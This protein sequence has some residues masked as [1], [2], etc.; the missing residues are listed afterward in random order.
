[1]PTPPSHPRRRIQTYLRSDLLEW[2]GAQAK[3]WHMT[4]AEVIEAALTHFQ[5]LYP[6]LKE[7]QSNGRQS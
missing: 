7:V 6:E 3:A 1:M 5:G 4:R 2:V